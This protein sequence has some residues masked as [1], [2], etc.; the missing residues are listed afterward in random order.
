MKRK[1]RTIKITKQQ[2]RQE[3]LARGEIVE[4]DDE[5]DE[6]DQEEGDGANGLAALLNQLNKLLKIMMAMTMKTMKMKTWLILKKM[7]NM[8]SVTSKIL[9]TKSLGN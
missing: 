9:K 3:A 2:E 4:D 8:K 6:D 1:K 7:W 5:M